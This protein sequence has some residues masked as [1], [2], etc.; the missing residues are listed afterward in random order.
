VGV[1]EETGLLGADA[2]GAGLGVE[3]A[4]RARAGHAVGGFGAGGFF[5]GGLRAVEEIMFGLLFGSWGG[6]GGV[7]FVAM[8]EMD[9]R[10]SAG[11]GSGGGK[12]KKAREDEESFHGN[13][14][15]GAFVACEE[16]GLYWSEG[17]IE[18]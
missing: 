6:G 8:P 13:H 17:H 18:G 14:L 16:E 12:R 15:R 2:G 7:F 10:R 5:A 4:D 1:G 3:V 9:F 11:D